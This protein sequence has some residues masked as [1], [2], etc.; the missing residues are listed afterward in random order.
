MGKRKVINQEVL[1]RE[2]IPFRVDAFLQMLARWVAEEIIKSKLK[3]GKTEDRFRE[4]RIG[5]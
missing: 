3:A 5:K 4:E 1:D 2:A